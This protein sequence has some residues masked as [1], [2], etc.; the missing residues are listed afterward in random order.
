MGDR[1]LEAGPR[2]HAERIDGDDERTGGRL[3]VSDDGVVHW[4]AYDAANLPTDATN[5]EGHHGHDDR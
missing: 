3:Y 1:I 5:R 4:R 2:G